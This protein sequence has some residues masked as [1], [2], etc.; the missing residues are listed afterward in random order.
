MTL[1]CHSDWWQ[2][3]HHKH[4]L[5]SSSFLFKLAYIFHYF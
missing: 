1:Q 4:S 2:I 5:G 3:T